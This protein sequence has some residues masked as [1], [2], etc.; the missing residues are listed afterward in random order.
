MGLN[1]WSAHQ[2]HIEAVVVPKMKPGQGISPSTGSR[3]KTN[4]S[5]RGIPHVVFGMDEFGIA[6]MYFSCRPL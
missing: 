3:S 1:T 6:N 5:S 2:Y 4:E